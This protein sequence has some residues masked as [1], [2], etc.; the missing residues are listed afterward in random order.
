MSPLISDSGKQTATQSDPRESALNPWGAPAGDT[1][2]PEGWPVAPALAWDSGRCSARLPAGP[3]GQ[4][5]CLPQCEDKPTGD[6][7]SGVLL[8]PRPDTVSWP[9]S[10]SGE[11]LDAGPVFGGKTTFA[12]GT[13]PRSNTER[14]LP[15]LHPSVPHRDARQLP[16]VCHFPPRG[17]LRGPPLVQLA[18]GSEVQ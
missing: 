7:V 5:H 6:M 3:W 10:G 2:P 17:D 12:K 14:P 11:G 4:Q 13:S 1:P 15:T 16:W 9:R 18:E 8:I